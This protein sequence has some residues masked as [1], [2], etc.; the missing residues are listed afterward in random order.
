MVREA[1]LTSPEDFS[2]NTSWSR[3]LLELHVSHVVL[4]SRGNDLANGLPTQMDFLLSP[5]LPWQTRSPVLRIP[6]SSLLLFWPG[7]VSCWSATASCSAFSASRMAA[8]H[9]LSHLSCKVERWFLWEQ[10]YPAREQCSSAG[11]TNTPAENNS[12]LASL[13]TD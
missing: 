6:E 4:P 13:L 1:S 10:L 8:T 3:R 5:L 2:R 7:V 12:F 11:F 9:S